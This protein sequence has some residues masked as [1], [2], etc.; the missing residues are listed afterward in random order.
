MSESSQETPYFSVNFGEQGGR[1]D[2]KTHDEVVNWISELQR[3]WD[4]L[5]SVGH[6]QT[7]NAWQIISQNLTAAINH[8]Q[9]ANQLKVQ[10]NQPQ[11]EAQLNAARTSLENFASQFPW[12]L[13]KSPLRLFV[14]DIRDNAHKLEAGLIVANWMNIDLNGAPIRYVVNALLKWEFYEHGIKNRMKT[15]NAA[16]KRLVGDMQ[17]QLTKFQESEDTQTNR[18][19]T[20]HEELINQQNK[21]QQSFNEYQEKCAGEWNQTLN[22][23]QASRH[24]SA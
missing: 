21:Q 6:G 2:W 13:P 11:V 20:L 19:N 3:Q 8:L 24:L 23:P 4:W 9:Q 18:F 17:T 14:E 7:N 15:E 5:S 16:L 22:R 1:Y 12:L 10:N